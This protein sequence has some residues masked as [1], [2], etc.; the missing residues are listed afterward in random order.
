M[1]DQAP[2]GEQ[3]FERLVGHRAHP[4]RFEPIEHLFE[5]RPLRVDEAVLEAGAKDPERHLREIAIVARRFQFCRRERLR[6]PSL[7]RLSAQPGARS[8]EDW[9]ERR[10]RHLRL[11]GQAER[12][13]SSNIIDAVDL[14]SMWYA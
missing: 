4:A 9:S 12:P 6:Q 14:L 1:A 7:E 8:L 10:G 2:V 3:G 5:G 11:I 13:G